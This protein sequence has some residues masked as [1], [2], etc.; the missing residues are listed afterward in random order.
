MVEEECGRAADIAVS[1]PDSL[2]LT[3]VAPPA[4]FFVRRRSRYTHRKT[5]ETEK[6][7]VATRCTGAFCAMGEIK[8]PNERRAR[9]ALSNGDSG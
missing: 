6:P 7:F 2:S 3:G 1:F 9:H 8:P 5:A 4:G